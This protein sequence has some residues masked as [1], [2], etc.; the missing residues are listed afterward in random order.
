[1][2]SRS[3]RKDLKQEPPELR[4]VVKK[5]AGRLTNDPKL[6]Q[7]GRT[8]MNGDG[9]RPTRNPDPRRRG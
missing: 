8:E 2:K 6:E 7:E 9:Q 5:M 1:M 4:G 3:P